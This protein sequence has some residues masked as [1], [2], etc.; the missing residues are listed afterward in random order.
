[1]GACRVLEIPPPS[2]LYDDRPAW[3]KAPAL[4]R[5]FV[6]IVGDG[7]APALLVVELC[8]HHADGFVADSDHGA[9]LSIVE[10]PLAVVHEL[11]AERLPFDWAEHE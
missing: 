2:S 4:S 9:P 10:P 8:P 7:H 6:R 3:C 11:A 5:L 1:M